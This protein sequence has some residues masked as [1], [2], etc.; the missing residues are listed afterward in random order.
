MTNTC[1]VCA[2]KAIYTIK[3]NIKINYKLV[4]QFNT[5]GRILQLTGL[6]SFTV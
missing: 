6:T 1:Q 4:K 2:M 3:M 5:N